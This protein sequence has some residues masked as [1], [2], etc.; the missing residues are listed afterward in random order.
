MLSFMLQNTRTFKLGMEKLNDLMQGEADNITFSLRRKVQLL[1]T[2]K[3]TLLY[4]LVCTFKYLD[5]LKSGN[6]YIHGNV[7]WDV[8]PWLPSIYEASFPSLA[9]QS[10]H[11]W[12]KRLIFEQISFLS[13]YCIKVHSNY[14]FVGNF[15]VFLLD[16]CTA[17]IRLFFRPSIQHR[18][19]HL[20]IFFLFI[21]LP[22]SYP[23]TCPS[24]YLSK[25]ICIVFS[26]QICRLINFLSDWQKKAQL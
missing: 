22:S 19:I 24:T 13:S 18:S 3:T 20:P 21:H 9:L 17:I 10:K 8:A 11:K 12:N 4:L 1:K 25:Q 2:F 5:G 23:S 15:V 16:S 6:I 7:D 26:V 14:L